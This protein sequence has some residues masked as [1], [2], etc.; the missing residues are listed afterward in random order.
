LWKK[1]QGH[2][3]E[4]CD[5]ISATLTGRKQSAEHIANMIAA[6]KGFKQSNKQKETARKLRSKTWMITAPNGQVT[7]VNNLVD[8]CRKSNLPRASVVFMHI[9]RGKPF[10]GFTFKKL[11]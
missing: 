11:D 8:F 5:K 1:G 4:T 3:R 7:I 10:R 9:K 2:T 6:K